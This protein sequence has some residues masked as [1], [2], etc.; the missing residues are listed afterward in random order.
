MRE[1]ELYRDNAALIIERF[2]KATLTV[3]EVAEYTG[4]DV[5]KVRK[6]FEKE[7]DK[8]GTWTLSA[9]VLARALS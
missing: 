9:M 8:D 2:G 1:K 6:K 5:R 3:K 4:W 7:W